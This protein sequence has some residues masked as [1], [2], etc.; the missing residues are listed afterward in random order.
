M[1][2]YAKA[3]SSPYVMTFSLLLLALAFRLHGI[4]DAPA[5][6]DDLYNYIAARSWA[7]DGTLAMAEGLYTRTR[8]YSVATAWLLEAFGPSLA[9]AR[10]LAA[11]GGAIMVALTALWVRNTSNAAAAWI[12][13]LLLCVSYTCITWSQV[14]RFYT[15]H[16]VAMLM[17]AIA[18]YA[19]VTSY[20]S[21]RPA[22]VGLCAISIVA[23]LL[24]GM[25]LQAITVVM[26]VAIAAWA[27]LFL[28][29]T[30]QL[31]FIF[32]SPKLR[33]A[34]L[35]GVAISAA[36][37]FT[38][39]RRTLL[40]MWMDLRRVSEWSSNN[41]DNW[42]F[43]FDQMVH[44]F[45]WLFF[46][47][48]IAFIISVRK[49]PAP[50]LFCAT[51]FTVCFALHT[52][53]GMKALRYIIYLFPFFFAIWGI[54]LSVILPAFIT[55]V[56][57]KVSASP[58]LLRP[59]VA[60]TVL[61]LIAAISLV[62]V[63]DFRMTA[64]A[65]A[66]SLRTGTTFQPLEYGAGRDQVFWEPYLP[67]LKGLKN[68]GL[69]VVSDSNRAI[70]YLDDYDLL[71][72]KTELSDIGTEEFLRDPRTGKRNISSGKSI[73]AVVDCY[74]KGVIL[75]SEA[76]WRSPYVLPDA[77]D[78]I[79]KIA[80]QVALPKPLNLRAYR[81]QHVVSSNAPACKSIYKMI[82]KSPEEVSR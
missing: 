33:I 47:F 30:G 23:G 57:S 80:T 21:L 9:V 32:A 2:Q 15:W 3:F 78:A 40:G 54:A 20:R 14:V 26:I 24:I 55:F 46:L 52:V 28:L 5:R 4:G 71:L 70:Y 58:A 29:L 51:I 11:I 61:G 36:G 13:G 69:F 49:Y 62:V 41:Q 43:Y 27:G 22:Q 77:A 63:A 7:Q 64:A 74:P 50:V 45:N 18:V 19:L 79:E 12:A 56:W 82:G 53:A 8:Y 34:A 16:A 68:S 66:R 44:Q 42:L 25:H 35:T 37:V 72:S 17:I 73:R 31:N 67:Q 38:V 65:M 48:P 6:M 76:Q 10:M 81:W 60:A 75:T 39:G 1:R 59:G